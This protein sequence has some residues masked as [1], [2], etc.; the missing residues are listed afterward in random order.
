MLK[1]FINKLLKTRVS[2]LIPDGFFLKIKFWINYDKKLDLKNP[3]TYNEKIQWLKINDRKIYYSNLVDKYEVKK[4]V[5]SLIG[6]KYIIPTIGVYENWDEINFN[7]LPNQ[8]VIKCTH[9][10]GGMIVCR[11][12]DSL[13][14][15][16]AKKKINK[17]M[18][19]NYYWLSR[20]WPY[21]N[22]KPR[23][24]VEKYLDFHNNYTSNVEFDSNYI[25]T[26][27]LQRE[28]GLLDYKFMCFNGKVEYLFLDIGV[29]GKGIGH[30]E[31]YYRNVYDSNFNI[32]PFLETR[33]NYPTRIE[34]PKNFEKMVEIAEKLSKNFKHIRVDLYN[35]DGK[36]YFG[37]LTFYH[38]GGLTNKFIPESY[39]DVFGD[40]IQLKK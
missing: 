14:L 24:I 29:I 2:R 12:K 4:Y 25:S 34:K 37:E 17:S 10:S 8:F 30:S 38:G 9:D 33:K 39:N 16:E 18:K 32:Q 26:E 6:E 40:L 11:N 3:H 19:R 27:Q 21:K 5:S 23:I 35:V 22:V 20:E 1:K 15:K 36:I 13:N 31:D 7:L 28:N